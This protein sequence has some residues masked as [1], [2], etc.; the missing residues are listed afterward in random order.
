M[1]FLRKLL[2]APSKI[3]L[4]IGFNCPEPP[5]ISEF[6]GLLGLSCFHFL[7]FWPFGLWFFLAFISFH[8]GLFGLHF[9]SF[10]AFRGASSFHSVFFAVFSFH[11][12]FFGF[13]FPCSLA[14]SS[15]ALPTFGRG[16]V[17]GATSG[18]VSPVQLVLNDAAGV[19]HAPAPVLHREG[20]SVGP[21][22]TEEDLL[23]ATW[24]TTK[25]SQ[26]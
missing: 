13:C 22:P 25:V 10:W 26:C 4:H 2:G 12:G 7:S 3:V 21:V 15:T 20:L 6:F 8:F 1:G 11:L 19:S 17:S 16:N 9:V 18:T 14:F 23:A 5:M 24:Q